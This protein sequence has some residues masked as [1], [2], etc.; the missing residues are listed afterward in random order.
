MAKN[1]K[2]NTFH[3]SYGNPLSSPGTMTLD[4]PRRGLLM[5]LMAWG[6]TQGKY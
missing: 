1:T 2:G 3:G 4:L 6:L 5:L